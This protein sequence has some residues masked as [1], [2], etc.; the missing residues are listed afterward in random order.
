MIPMDGAKSK[1]KRWVRLII[2]IIGITIL[3]VIVQRI[4][5]ASR[6]TV[7]SPIP[8]T[9]ITQH[10]QKS[11][12]FTLFKKTK[13]ADDLTDKINTAIDESWT[14]YSI[15][16]EDY[17]SDFALNISE[18]EIFIAASVNKIPILAALYYYAGKGEIDLDRDITVQEADI[19]DYGT[20][21]LR[22]EKPGSVY[23]IKTLAKL[24]IKQSD[25]TAAYIL[26]NHIV[27][28]DKLSA[29]ISQWGMVQT[30]MVENKTSNRDIAKI[31]RLIYEGKITNQ[32]ATLEMLSFL[33][34]TDHETRLPANLPD[35]TMTYHKIGTEVGVIHDAGVVT[36]GK[37]TY[38]VGIFTSG[39][40]ESE[41]TDKQFAVISKIIYDFMKQ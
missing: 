18:G 20:G 26:A 27:G 6:Y 14:D 3:A 39:T 31:M 17:T 19:Q 25:N 15:V 32:A 10:T 37:H 40:E 12:P 36:D 23:S 8:D 35:T 28:F 2:L 33:K 13:N 38:Y 11:K 24:M 30:D 9:P 7:I 5:F 21:S 16:V 41:E 34:D 1:R 4:V 29:A 22:Y